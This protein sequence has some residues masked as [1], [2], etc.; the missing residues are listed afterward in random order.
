[1]FAQ[2][3]DLHKNHAEASSQQPH[4]TKK[5]PVAG[6]HAQKQVFL[7]SFPVP[8]STTLPHGEPMKQENQLRV[9]LYARVS[10][11]D[12][13]QD[14]QNQLQQ[15]REFCSKQGWQI[16][17]EYT[18]RASGKRGDRAEFQ[19][20]FD[21]ASRC[22]YDCLVFWS[23]DRFSREGVLET[24]QHLQ[25]LTGYGVA[26]RSFTE[27]Y[28]DSIGPFRDVVISL[29][30]ALARQERVRLSERVVAGLARARKEGRVGGRP[31]AIV[32][33]SKMRKLA[34]QGLSAV[35]IGAQLGVS[36]MTVARRLGGSV[37]TGS[38]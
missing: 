35:Q 33:T 12:G 11:R 24:L 30:A 5:L 20:A 10:T 37:R 4:Q 25:R 7:C 3:A 27:S 17:K 26:Y 8:Y 34:E 21:A 1:V 32:S 16:V 23:L 22:E 18:D 6:M 38:Q 31:K 36:R 29:L 19:A 15:L 13:R 2:C 14:T 9:A 28:I